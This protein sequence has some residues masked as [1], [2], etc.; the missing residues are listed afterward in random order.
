GDERGEDGK[1]FEV[2]LN[3]DGTGSYTFEL[4][5]ALDH[6]PPGSN[7][8]MV[9]WNLDFNITAKD[10]DGDTVNG[11]FRVVV[12]DD[13]PTADYSGRITLTETTDEDGDFVEQ[14]ASGQMIFDGG[15]DGATVTEIRYESGEVDGNTAIIDGDADSF[16]RVEFTSGG[17][18]VIVTQS[19]DGLTLTGET[20]SGL[21]V[22]T[23]TVDSVETGE[24]TFTQHAAIDHPDA[25]ETGAEDPL[26][27]KI[28]FTVTDG[29]G[30][31]A[32][33]SFQ[34]DINDDGPSI[35][36]PTAK[37]VSEVNLDYGS[38]TGY[39][40]SMDT[41]GGAN[42]FFIEPGADFFKVSGQGVG[43][44]QPV[45]LELL[46]ELWNGEIVTRGNG[47]EVRGNFSKNDPDA[48]ISVNDNHIVNIGGRDTGGNYKFRFD[49]EQDAK[50]FAEF[51][52]DIK[53]DGYLN[54]L[55][56]DPGQLKVKGDLDIDWGA[57]SVDAAGD[58][59]TAQDD[60][61]V[62]EGNR[63][64]T[65]SDTQTPGNNV[66]VKNGDA[67]VDTLMSR[68][69][70]VTYSLNGDGTVLTASAGART[71]FTVTLLDDGSGKYIL[72]MVDTLDHPA[73]AEDDL[74]LSFDFTARDSDGDTADGRFVVTVKDDV[75]TTS[76]SATVK[77]TE[78]AEANGDFITQSG[79][80]RMLFEGGAD[81]AE[82]TEIRYETDTVAGKAGIADGESGEAVGFTSGGEEVIITASVDGLTLTGTTVGGTK[83]FTVTVT[84][85]E[86]GRFT[87]T[88]YEA[89]DHPDANETGAADPLSMTIGYTVTDGDGDTANGTVEVTIKDD[90]P[91]IGTPSSSTISEADLA[92]PGENLIVN[93]SFEQPELGNGKWSNYKDGEGIEGWNGTDVEIQNQYEGRVASDGEQYLEIDAA[94]QVDTVSQSVQTEA[95]AQYELSFDIAARGDG[96]ETI[97][98]YWNGELL[99]AEQAVGSDWTT[100]SFVVT[101]TGGEDT[102]EFRE[103]AGENNTYGGFIDNVS[104]YKIGNTTPD[105]AVDG[106]AHSVDGDLN[107]DWGSDSADAGDDLQGSQDDASVVLGNRAVLFTDDSVSVTQGGEAVSDLTSKGEKV[108][109]ALSENNTVLTATAGGR[110]VFTVTLLDDGSG[111][112]ILDM[113]D[114][115]DH[116]TDNPGVAGED[117]ELSFEFVAR[118]SDGDLSA[119]GEFTVTVA[120]DPLADLSVV[121]VGDGVRSTHYTTDERDASGLADK[122]GQ[123]IQ[124]NAVPD[125][126]VITMEDGV[127]VVAADSWNAA[128]NV[129]YTSGTESSDK[130]RLE[131]FVH[132]DADTRL[133][134]EGV[135]LDIDNAKRGNIAMG[136]GDDQLDISLATNGS[137][138]S[139]KFVIDT[140]DGNDEVIIQPGEA[141]P[142]AGITDG[143]YT[144]VEIKLGDG[145][146]VY[147]NTTEASDTVYGGEGNDIARTGAGDDAMYG[148]GGNDTFYGGAGDDTYFMTDAFGDDHVDGGSAGSDM[149]TLDMSA[150]TEDLTFTGTNLFE[151]KMATVTGDAGTAT[152]TEIEQIVSGGGDDVFTSG[153]TLRDIQK[154]SMGGGNDTFAWLTFNKDQLEIDAGEGDDTV[155]VGGAIGAGHTGLIDGTVNGGLGTDTLAV[156]FTLGRGTGFNVVF[157]GDNS[158]T[159]GYIDGET[160][161]TRFESFEEFTFGDFKNDKYNHDHVDASASNAD[162]K[163]ST[164]RGDDTVIGGAGNDTIDGGKGNDVLEGGAGA[165]AL[166]GGEGN[167]TAS[168]AGSSEAVTVNL[169]DGTAS[170]GDATGDTLSSIENL[171]G[172]DHDDTLTGDDNANQIEGGLG[173]DLLTGG[174]G[175]DTI[176]GGEGTD[177][178]VYTGSVLDYR[179]GHQTGFIEVVDGVADRDGADKVSG[180]EKLT[181]AEG[182][183]VW[184]YGHN[185]TDTLVAEDGVNTLLV[186][187]HDNDTLT[188]GTGDDVLFGDHGVDFNWQPGND[189]LDGGAGN[190]ILVGGGGDD[191]LTGGEGN[192]TIK[193][194]EGTDTAVYTGSVLDYRF[195]HQTGFIEVVDGVAD[196]DGADKVSGVEKL[197]F[198]EGTYVWTYG[199]NAGDTLVAEDG[200]NTLLVG[201]HG[202]DTLTGGTGDDV[203]FGDHGVDFNWQPGNDV[204][205]GGA[206]NDIL[207]G[208][209]GD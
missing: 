48:K 68:G 16:T 116:P 11:D 197:T 101:G 18:D 136:D 146:D 135:S 29:D 26:R 203:L 181:F 167:D 42:R 95:G 62:L 107:V 198:A 104:L 157:D 72:E 27:M 185:A 2:S 155:N 139:N 35:G 186:G 156:Q 32:S 57:D 79:K 75:P 13:A 63:A 103:P 12:A 109:F 127:E 163:I 193:G 148:G 96:A 94:G 126:A 8:Q 34:V 112:Y 25:N 177:T 88:Q 85:A 81:D 142:S 58:S 205:D 22:F 207:V 39:S 69:E 195:G 150:V 128:K 121:K 189:I 55:F 5:G 50:N 199:H 119:P 132:V 200:V 51:L 91:S 14:S 7:G 129:F 174:E 66:V 21:K 106:Y 178:A 170:G 44:Q 144:E 10:A 41:N 173:A 143:R 118:D 149:D 53:A 140:G 78:D 124:P 52:Q 76:D 152:F 179:F 17:E 202:N 6:N 105:G 196:R 159:V 190:D 188:G 164:A 172:S 30:D 65:F 37:T 100:V 40:I 117:L 71:V 113:L 98:V 61:S 56:S 168:Y 90:G 99:S 125:E 84:D 115:L 153:Y 114:T 184:T 180:V 89:I 1:V 133:K 145:D 137:G 19:A 162:L 147:E 208:G 138:Y 161:Q 134:D 93:G 28:G 123:P 47:S 80:G 176:K 70:E 33:R 122:L 175:N 54:E 191:L 108:E 194:G 165:D 97:E 102:L 31:T 187:F 82:V 201:F 154:I 92:V 111:Q 87:F 151:T 158:G 60:A 67:V 206:G 141:Q 166:Y 15:A 23:L 73:G 46:G 171:I 9:S 182:T 49:N 192:D 183:Y 130:V 20:S 120:D 36:E 43:G 204:L 45:T 38:D 83:V 4:L 77:V 3:D 169:A 110:T 24:Y 74:A 131:D 64:V 59:K 86:T 160:T 209:G